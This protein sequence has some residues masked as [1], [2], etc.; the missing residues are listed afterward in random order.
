MT[1]GADI[2]GVVSGA[3]GIV[4][5]GITAYRK[6]SPTRAMDELDSGLKA[7]EAAVLFAKESGVIIDP[8][9]WESLNN[10]IF[11]YVA[12]TRTIS[13]ILQRSPIPS[14]RCSAAEYRVRITENQ[15]FTKKFSLTLSGLALKIRH[16]TTE[17]RQVRAEI[18]VR[19]TLTRYHLF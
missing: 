19:R 8:V 5:V 4:G 17:A 6:S 15:T 11:G 18:L 7:A 14:I 2:F 1:S 13:T 16:F 3:L 12:P 10:R 9:L